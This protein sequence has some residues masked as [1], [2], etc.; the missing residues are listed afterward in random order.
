MKVQ[1]TTRKVTRFQYAA[2]LLGALAVMVIAPA[3]ANA[4]P[5][6]PTNPGGCSYT[7]AGGDTIPIDNNQDVIVDGKIVSCRD[8]KTIVTTPPKRGVG[9]VRPN[10]VGSVLPVL[11]QMP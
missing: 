7:D 11:V 1:S 9:N 4:Q 3:T 6:E 2:T 10:V 8:G 5:I